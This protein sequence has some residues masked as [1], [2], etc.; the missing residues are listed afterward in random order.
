MIGLILTVFRR[1]KED[2]DAGN[3]GETANNIANLKNVLQ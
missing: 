1:L 3:T 2:E